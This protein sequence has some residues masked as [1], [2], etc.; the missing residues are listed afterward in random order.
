M[1]AIKYIDDHYY[2]VNS[3]HTLNTY[4]SESI[5]LFEIM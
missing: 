2:Y 1:Y 5:L 4:T 3:I